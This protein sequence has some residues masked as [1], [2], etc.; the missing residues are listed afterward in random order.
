MT[1]P[2]LQFV[3]ICPEKFWE[4]HIALMNGQEDFYDI[5]SAN[6]TPTQTRAK[7]VELALPIVGE[8]KKGALT[9]LLAHKT[10]PNGGLAVTDELKYTSRLTHVATASGALLTSH[11]QVFPSELDSC[12]PHCPLGWARRRRDFQQLGRKGVDRFL[13]IQGPHLTGFKKLHT[14]V[15]YSAIDLH[16][17]FKVLDELSG[18]SRCDDLQQEFPDGQRVRGSSTPLHHFSNEFVDDIDIA[19]SDSVRDL[20]IRFDYVP[21]PRFHRRITLVKGDERVLLRQLFWSFRGWVIQH[22][23]YDQ[24]SGR[25]CRKTR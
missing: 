3:R 9:D 13:G 1:S 19:G 22:E 8:D 20:R 17:R 24:L 21:A 4:L 23:S 12:L 11:S 7:L 5:P 16:A 14:C 25:A 2:F 6:R 18:A 10:T 15:Y